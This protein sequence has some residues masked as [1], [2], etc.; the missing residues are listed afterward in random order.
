MFLIVV[1][2]LA[3]GVLGSFTDRRFM[4][5]LFHEAYIR[6]PEI[7]RHEIMAGSEKR[8]ILFSKPSAW[9]SAV[10]SLACA[11][12]PCDQHYPRMLVTLMA[13][14]AGSLG[15]MLINGLFIKLDARVIAAHALGYFV[16]FAVAGV[17][18]ELALSVKP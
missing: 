13:W 6:Y 1:A 18:S 14:I 5:V 16:R 17:A 8:A 11:Y 4:G 9:L 2:A 15:L 3:A 7:W 12:G 10:P